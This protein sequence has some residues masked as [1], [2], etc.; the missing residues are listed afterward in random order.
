MASKRE[1]NMARGYPLPLWTFQVH[2]SIGKQECDQYGEC[3]DCGATCMVE[4]TCSNV[5][6]RDSDNPAAEPGI[7]VCD[8]CDKTRRARGEANN[9]PWAAHSAAQNAV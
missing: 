2:G 7:V 8:S 3:A 6:P 9:F 5:W 1:E 4:P